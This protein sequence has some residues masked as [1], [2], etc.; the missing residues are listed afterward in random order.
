MNIYINGYFLSSNQ[1]SGVYRFAYNILLE[2]DK[3]LSESSYGKFILVVPDG[4]F[5]I[6]QLMKVSVYTLH[7]IRYQH[8]WEQVILV[9]LVR[10]NFLINLAN[11]APILKK[12]QLCVIH[13]ALVFR[14]PQ[15]YSKKFVLLTK[16][17][18]KLIFKNTQHIATVSEFSKNELITC[19]N[20]GKKANRI[21]VL[22]NSAEHI[23]KIKAD[24]EV[25]YKNKLNSKGYVL[26]VLSQRNSFYKNVELVINISKQCDLPVICVG[27]VEI[28]DS[29]D[30]HNL[31]CL[32]NVT[33]GELKALYQSAKLLLVPSFYEGFGIP[34]LE[35]MEN[36]CPVVVSDI[37]IFREICGSSANY[38]DPYNY[39]NAISI[40]NSSI[41]NDER[42]NYMIKHGL[43]VVSRYKWKIFA[44]KIL[45]VVNDQ[46]TLN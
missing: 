2:L 8:I 10:D 4:N 12:N 31:T 5:T 25:I 17:F 16:F 14:Y 21:L 24:N 40:I 33:D 15:S 20:Q 23:N 39:K 1:N 27:S 19:I 29:A 28:I 37:P 6:P 42:L 41:N 7:G 22:G 35:A 3:L 36:E 11:F 9:K 34:I 38:I 44:Q 46:D 13:D 43:E 32:G 45:E 26:V 30:K 18:H